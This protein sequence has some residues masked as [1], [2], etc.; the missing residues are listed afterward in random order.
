[1]ESSTRPLKPVPTV[2]LPKLD[3]PLSTLTALFTGNGDIVSYNTFYGKAVAVNHPDYAKV[4]SKNSDGF[5]RTPLIKI[6]GGEGLVGSEG[7][8][9]HNQRRIAQPS[10]HMHCLHGFSHVILNQAN[11]MLEKWSDPKYQTEGFDFFMEIRCLTMQVITETML[12]TTLD[13]EALAEWVTLFNTGLN[14]LRPFVVGQLGIT[15]S[16]SPDESR[17]QKL[18]VKEL[19]TLI[20]EMID[21][22]RAQ[23]KPP[24]DLLTNLIQSNNKATAAPLTD[25][26]IRDEVFTMLLAGHETTAVTISWILNELLKHEETLKAVVTEIDTVLGNDMPT[27][28]NLKELT[29]LNQVINETIRLNPAAWVV[30]RVAKGDQAVGD[31]LIPDNTLVLISI[32]SMHRHPDFWE[33]PT[34]FNPRHFEPDAV[35]ARDKSAYMPFLTGKH[36]CIG[37]GFALLESGLVIARFLQHYTFERIQGSVVSSIPGFTLQLNDGLRV[38]VHNRKP[39]KL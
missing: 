15:M 28:E 12:S 2:T 4:I 8:Y 32:Y 21:Q 22:R 17:K 34:Q 33:T 27:H 29:Y 19:D 39:S 36:Q 38:R 26:Q 3:D 14:T 35:E 7:A 30:S 13:P 10:F 1:M 37:Q 20:Y 11:V 23:A 9:W 31:Y 18:A 25:Q 5:V 6:I 16:V 24:K